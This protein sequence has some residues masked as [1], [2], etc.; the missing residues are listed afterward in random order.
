M[1]RHAP[2]RVVL[3]SGQASYLLYGDPECDTQS[4]RYMFVRPDGERRGNA[5][6]KLLEEGWRIVSISNVT[7][8]QLPE[9]RWGAALVVLEFVGN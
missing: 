8:T 6:P 1:A 3:T 5:L 2:Q 7:P 9:G 4:E